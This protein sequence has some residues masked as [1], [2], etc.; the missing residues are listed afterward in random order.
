MKYR[1]LGRTGLIVSEIGLGGHEYRRPL[2]TTLLK[3]GEI[4][5]EKFMAT[6]PVRNEIVR[7]A[8]DLGINY[9]DITFI[10]EAM[11]LGNALKSLRI[12]R[13]RIH[14]AAMIISPFRKMGQNHRSR[15]VDIIKDEIERILGALHTKYIDVFNLTFPEDDYSREKFDV[16]MNIFKEAKEEGKIRWIGSS[17]HEPYF[18]AELIRKYDCFDTVMVRYNYYLQEARRILFPLCKAMEIGL[19]IMKPFCWPYYGIPFMRFGPVKGEEE[20]LYT[21]AQLCLRWILKSQEVSTVVP[22]VNNLNELEENVAALSKDEK[23]DE[24]ILN[25]Y[26]KVA[27]GPE[28]KEK[29]KRMTSDPNIDI[30]F[31]AERALSEL[32]AN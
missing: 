31:F 21:P 5:M 8:I 15:W 26:L 17:S 23:I 19:V 12:E 29:L 10:E 27:T 13:E 6:Q 24:R 30:K 7:R 11:S 25:E 22:S 3:W 16:L 20:N 2:P 4:D 14:I 1:V 18:L 9:F 28:A 32:E